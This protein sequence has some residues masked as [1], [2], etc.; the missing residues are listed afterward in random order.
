MTWAHSDGHFESMV[1]R[2]ESV[3]FSEDQC[4]EL[5]KIMALEK[6]IPYSTVFH[7]F[8]LMKREMKANSAL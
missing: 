6:F 3:P 4:L 2:A 1:T 5:H 8:R 7:A